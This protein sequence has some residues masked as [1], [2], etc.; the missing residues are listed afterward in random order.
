MSGIALSG[1]ASGLDT[2]A[3]ISA[4]MAVNA[5]PLNALKI[6]AQQDQTVQTSLQGIQTSLQSLN[7]AASSL[8]SVLNWLPTQSGDTSNSGI[9]GVSITG[10]AAAGAYNLNVDHL[11]QTAQGSFEIDPGAGATA[12][13]VQASDGTTTTF[14]VGGMTAQA[15]ADA[16]NGT[17]GAPISAA[18][19]QPGDGTTRLVLTS[20]TTGGDGNFT[21]VGGVQPGTQK[22]W[23][24]GQDAQVTLDG[25]TYTSKTNTMDNVIPGVELNLKSAGAATVT[26]SPPTTNDDTVVNAVQTFVDAYNNALKTVKAATDQESVVNPQSTDD[27]M[28]GLLHADSGLNSLLDQLRNAISS[29]IQGGSGTLKTFADLGISTGATT[30]SGTVSQDALD[31][32]LSFDADTLRSQLDSNPDGVRAALGATTGATGLSQVVTAVT[33]PQIQFGGVFDQRL[34]GISDDIADI[35][36]QESD[37]QDRLDQTQQRLQAQF[38]AMETAL[39]QSQAQQQWLTGQINSLG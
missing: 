25:S 32:V 23:R 11:A 22:V 2:N 1:L 20:R 37:M 35:T 39:S 19:I 30:G 6:K 21:F 29:P 9:A 12:F 31:G 13:S 8:S 36:Q 27:Q 28:Q 26:V 24:P 5:Q 16:I 34:N 4:L 38:T 7:D 14:N 33:G 10:G 15:A 17:A 3:M 18:V